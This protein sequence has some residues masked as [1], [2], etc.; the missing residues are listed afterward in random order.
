MREA[1]E[2]DDEEREPEYVGDPANLEVGA[3]TLLAARSS[4]IQSRL[5]RSEL[6]ATL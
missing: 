4:S 3:L 2:V 1:D 6:L 5:T